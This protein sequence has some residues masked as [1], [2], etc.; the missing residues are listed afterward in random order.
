M[1]KKIIIMASIILVIGIVVATVFL[2]NPFTDNLNITNCRDDYTCLYNSILEGKSS[3]VIINEEMPSLGIIEKSEIKIEPKNSQY[4]VTFRIINLEKIQKQKSVTKSIVESISE[5]CPRIL[6]NL[7]K[8][9]STSAVCTVP[10]PE[11]AKNLAVN[12]LNE[13]VIKKYSCSGNLISQIQNICI[14]SDFPH[15]PPGVKKPAV[16]LYP[17]EKSNIRV[18]IDINGFITKSEPSY[19]NGWDVVAEPNGLIDDKYDYLFYE[20]QLRNLK[21]SDKGWVVEYNDLENWF[22]L[23]LIKLGLNEKE[24]NQFKEYWL[25]ELPKSNYY[26]IKMLEDSFLKENMNL[27]ISPQP[28]TLIRLN[29]YFKPLKE[30]I[31][32][33]EPTISTPGRNGFTVVEW[34]GLLDN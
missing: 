30:K 34:G 31:E 28:E 6:D 2:L 29:F 8:I 16:Y 26:E 32:L 10:T 13:E 5:D 11:E 4:E 33:P 25:E 3:K 23:N 20:A 22:N 12:G 19:L 24:K 7:D 15:F 21:V 14:T 1:N 27:I 9:E 17:I 18:L